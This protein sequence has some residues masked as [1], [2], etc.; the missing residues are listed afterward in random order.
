M[1]FK[2]PVFITGN[3]RNSTVSRSAAT[4]TEVL[5]CT[6]LSKENNCLNNSKNHGYNFGTILEPQKQTNWKCMAIITCV[7]LALALTYLGTCF[8]RHWKS[9]AH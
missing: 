5:S 6:D 8:H 1:F 3:E 7:L 4:V 2:N 9:R